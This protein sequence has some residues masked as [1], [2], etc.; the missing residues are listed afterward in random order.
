MCLSEPLSLAHLLRSILP[1]GGGGGHSPSRNQSEAMQPNSSKSS[2]SGAVS[3]AATPLPQAKDPQKQYA[4]LLAV[5]VG[6]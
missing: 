2:F 6:G 1:G 5:Q 3:P 4:L